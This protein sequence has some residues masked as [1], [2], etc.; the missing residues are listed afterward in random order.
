MSF[1]VLIQDNCGIIKIGSFEESFE[2]FTDHYTSHDY[3][4]QW[5]TALS[6]IVTGEK[7]IVTLMTSWFPPNLKANLSA[8]VLYR[9]NDTV[10]I[11][12][13]IY[14][15]DEHEFGLDDNGVVIENEPRETISEEGDQI[16]EWKTSVEEINKF[17]AKFN[18]QLTNCLN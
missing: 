2:I 14:I 12:E 5:N 15:P 7:K 8:W 16:S 18:G 3:L 1:K 10:Y 13:K 11:H 17:L 6:K 9:E 4:R